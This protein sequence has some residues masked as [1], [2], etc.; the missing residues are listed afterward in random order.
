MNRTLYAARFKSWTGGNGAAINITWR[1]ITFMDVIFPIDVTQNY[2][3]QGVGP[4]PNSSSLNETHIENFLFHNFTGV[5]NDTPGYV[6]GS[7]VTDPCWYSVPGATGKEV[8]IFD[9]YPNTA[10]NIVA[11]DLFATTLTGAPVAVMCN[12]STVSSDVGFVCQD[13]PYIPT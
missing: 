11:K 5:I 7:C 10:T 1:D 13:G 4:R 12:S 6:E 3:D 2:W 8:V 9:L